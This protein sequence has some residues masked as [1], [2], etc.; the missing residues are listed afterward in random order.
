[1][2]AKPVDPKAEGFPADEDTTLRQEI[3]KIRRA[4]CKAMAGPDR[5]GDDLAGKT[6]ALQAWH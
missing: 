2:R 1:M 4:E 6:K 5:I 3:L